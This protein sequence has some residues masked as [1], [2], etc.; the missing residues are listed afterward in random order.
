M[1]G[2]QDETSNGSGRVDIVD[3]LNGNPRSDLN[4]KR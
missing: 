4:R 2:L 3:N 1:T